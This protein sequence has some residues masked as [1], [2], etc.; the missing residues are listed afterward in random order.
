MV[1]FSADGS[2]TGAK[3]AFRG[4]LHNLFETR[5][6]GRKRHSTVRFH[7][8]RP[9]RSPFKYQFTHYYPVGG[10]RKK[11]NPKIDYINQFCG[12]RHHLNKIRLLVK[13]DLSIKMFV[14]SSASC[15]WYC[16]CCCCKIHDKR[17]TFVWIIAVKASRPNFTYYHH[18]H[19]DVRCQRIGTRDQN[20]VMVCRPMWI[21]IQKSNV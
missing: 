5:I 18:S 15:E 21:I 16:W 17:A 8:H 19:C 3:N 6:D 13:P 9:Y 1:K 14:K 7:G 2:S 12:W 11:I 10:I 20:I 4:M